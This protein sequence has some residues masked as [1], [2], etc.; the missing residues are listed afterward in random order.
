MDAE[1]DA[2]NLT[3][4]DYTICVKNIP[5]DLNVD[6]KWELHKIFETTAV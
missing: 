2:A 4:A 5:T 1:I 6:Y 3:P